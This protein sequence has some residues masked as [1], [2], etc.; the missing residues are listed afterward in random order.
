MCHNELKG[1]P[2]FNVVDLLTDIDRAIVE[3]RP[4]G[5]L[6]PNWPIGGCF[7]RELAPVIS[8]V[9]FL[10]DFAFC[11]VPFMLFSVASSTTFCVDLPESCAAL[12]PNS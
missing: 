4:I 2:G 8:G 9:Y 6:E 11:Q 5:L 10:G 7:R 12:A 3:N 1:G